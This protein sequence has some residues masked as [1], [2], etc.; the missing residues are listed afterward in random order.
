MKKLVLLAVMAM[1]LAVNIP[2]MAQPLPVVV[3]SY[4]T[5]IFGKPCAVVVTKYKG[6][7]GL[8]GQNQVSAAYF[9]KD[10]DGNPVSAG[11]PVC[12]KSDGIAKAMLENAVP[13][14]LTGGLNIIAAG[15]IRPSRTNV[16]VPVSGVSNAS[17][18]A[19]QGQVGIN[20]QAQGQLQGQ[21]QGQAQGQQQQQGQAGDRSTVF[22]IQ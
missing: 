15:Q 11:D 20:A 10:A 1:V 21:A 6:G 13:A 4:E 19:K 2:A 9:T 17:S 12:S 14:G 18:L 5:T 3:Q 22:G 16:T 7:F 8:L